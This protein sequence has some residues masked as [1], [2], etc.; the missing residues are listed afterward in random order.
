MPKFTKGQRVKY[1]GT[2]E[3]WEYRKGC[4]GTVQ[5]DTYSDVELVLVLFDGEDYSVYTYQANVETTW[6][7]PQQRTTELSTNNIFALRHKQ[8][9]EFGVVGLS[10]NFM[11]MIIREAAPQEQIYCTT[12]K[13]DAEEIA[14]INPQ[15]EAVKFEEVKL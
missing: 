6:A 3:G 9:K 14:K 8:T 5:E 2:T 11:G 10:N 13:V 4:L 7:Q 15:W 12:V 1:C